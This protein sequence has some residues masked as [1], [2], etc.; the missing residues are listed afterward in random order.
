MCRMK[1]KGT[2]TLLNRTGL[3]LMSSIVPPS[4][5]ICCSCIVGP[6]SSSLALKFGTKL[7][8]LRPD[9]NI[10]LR[11]N[12]YNES[13]QDIEPSLGLLLVTRHSL[14][15]IHYTSDTKTKTHHH[16]LN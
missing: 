4:F 6:E 5:T 8:E 2:H 7:W 13:G 12:G 15:A 14:S 9:K 16:Q 3:D 11:W 1:G 10:E